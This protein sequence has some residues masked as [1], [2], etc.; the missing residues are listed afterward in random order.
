[1]SMPADFY[2]GFRES[3]LGGALPDPGSLKGKT[4]TAQLAALGWRILPIP[5]FWQAGRLWRDHRG[6]GNP[7]FIDFKHPH[8]WLVIPPDSA[9][10]PAQKFTGRSRA[11]GW[12]YRQAVFGKGSA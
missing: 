3:T 9:G 1:M 5:Y 11:I 10:V 8:E 12:A 6:N 7:A 4:K 2:F